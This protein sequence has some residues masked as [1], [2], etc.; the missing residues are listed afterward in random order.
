V[1]GWSREA[2][3]AA[4]G[5]PGSCPSARSARGPQVARGE[6]RR[7][8]AVAKAQLLEH[9]S[10]V[11]LDRRLGD[12]QPLGDLA[13]AQ[14]GAQQR[15]HLV[16]A[17]GELRETLERGSLA[18][19]IRSLPE[20]PHAGHLAQLLAGHDFQEAFKNLR[21]LQ[22][23]Q[24]NLQEWSERL[25]TFDDMLANRR[26]AFA[27]R[28]PAVRQRAAEVSIPGLE[29]RRDTLAAELARAETETDADAFVDER[30]RALLERMQRVYQGLWLSKDPTLA[31]RAR[32]LSGALTWELA[33]EFPARL[34]E[35]KKALKATDAALAEAKQHDAAL[36]KAQQEEPQRFEAF[37]ARV[38]ALSGRVNGG[39]TQAAQIEEQLTHA[40]GAMIG[41]EAYHHPWSMAGWDQ[42]YLGAVQSA[43]PSRNAVEA[44]MVAYMERE[45]A[46]HGTPWHGI[47]RHMMGLYNGQPGARRW[48]QVWSD[49]RLKS[50][51]ATQVMALAHAAVEEVSA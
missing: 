39:L 41:R 16:L 21:D 17:L 25:G 6:R 51:R 15:E 27:E 37:A 48:R 5:G 4:S 30:Q 11:R 26:K 13:V 40:D 33:R 36:A 38:A 28:L 42:R 45:A 29:K 10:H 32:R 34:W 35:A 1:G 22:F 49:H 23:L 47:A 20:M 19:S 2:C 8:G 3:S 46:A 9:V 12:E 50:Q 24:R 31:E 44:A 14:A 43:S 7:L 18:A